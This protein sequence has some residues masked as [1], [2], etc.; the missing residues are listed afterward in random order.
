[1]ISESGDGR[2]ALTAVRK[3]RPDVVIMDISMPKLNGIEATR[4]IHK[5][6]PKTRMIALTIH[7][8]V[9]YVAEMMRAGASGYLLK[10]CAS[11]ELI[12]AV[13]TV[14]RGDTYLSPGIASALVTDYLRK[15]PSSAKP[16]FSAL[17]ER[18]R[19]ILQLLAEGI[20][21]QQIG[22][23]LHVSRKTIET[24]RRRIMQKLNVKTEADLVKRAIRNGVSSIDLP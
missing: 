19:E 21:P 8:D 6:Y 1:M 11:R 7:D 18:E 16:S 3:H 17:T 13:H 22:E 9:E 12:E 4:K 20:R 15:V 5:E 23:Q 14:A 10:H 24:H 2:A